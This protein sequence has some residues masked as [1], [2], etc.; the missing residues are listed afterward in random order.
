MATFTFIMNNPETTPPYL[1]SLNPAQLSAAL[2][3]QGPV[4]IIAGAGSGKTRVLTYRIAHLLHTRHDAFSIMALTF[5]NKAAQEMRERIQQIVGNEARNVFMGTFHSVFARLLRSEATKLGYPNEFSIY[6]A[7]DSKSLLKTILKEQGIDPKI[8]KPSVV[9]NKISAAK[10][11]LVSPA[12]YLNDTERM[13]NDAMA[14]LSRVG[15]LYQRYAQRCFKAGAM[16]FDDLLFKMHQLL[17]DFPDVLY[18]YQHRFKQ[19]LVDEYQDTNYAQY[20]IIKMLA[21]VHQNICVVGDDAQSIYAFRGATISNILNFS[22]DYPDTQL[23]KLEQNYRSTKNILGAATDIIDK[24][25]GQIPKV[26]WTE[27]DEGKKINLIKAANDTDEALQVARTITEQKMMAQLKNQDF[28]ILYRTNAQSRSFEESM[29]KLNLPYKVYGGMSF[30]QRKEIKDLLAYVRLAINQNDEEAFKRIINYPK[31]GIGDKAIEKITI[32]AEDNGVALWT[33]VENA[34]NFALGSVAA[35]ITDFSV[36]MQ[37]F[38]S[39][40]PKLDA[41]EATKIIAKHS[42]L[43]DELYREKSESFEASARVEN[44][45][46]LLNGIKNFV[47]DPD[48]EDKSLSSYLQSIALHTTLDQ[49]DQNPD[50]ISLMTIHNAKGLEFSQVFIVGLEENLFPSNMAMASRE[51]LEEERRLF[52][53][54]LTRAEQH[55]HLTYALVRFRFGYLNYCEPSRFLNEIDAQRLNIKI[56]TTP[57][58]TPDTS[59]GSNYQY[60]KKTALARPIIAPL[61]KNTTEND[62]EYQIILELE[63]GATVA[64]QRFGNGKV[65]ATEGA[66]ADRRATIFF[67]GIGQKS[68]VLKFAKLKRTEL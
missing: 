19:I 64:H 44:F 11:E 29:R 43:K 49:D 31:R 59:S 37:Y 17:M 52:Y 7:D 39:Q 25:K 46:E 66:G 3:I 57:Q 47:A 35:K 6:D 61:Y 22:K 28:A 27:N 48:V 14:G 55:L 23:F 2:A 68:L 53:V 21:A 9:F 42:G 34:H 65:I 41:Y 4:M 15:E 8:Y 13:A 40:I 36:M 54:A 5:T 63:V 58:Y 51:E 30:Y 38:I 16:D 33:V 10:N 67:E 26:L 60:L 12:Q 56:P 45:E 24:N 1:K 62:G 20:K 18:K 32:A 50:R